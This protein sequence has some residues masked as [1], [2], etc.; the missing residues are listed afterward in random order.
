[1]IIRPSKIAWLYPSFEAMLWMHMSPPLSP[2]TYRPNIV[3]P[4]VADF[5]TIE[6]MNL[7]VPRLS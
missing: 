3:L 1:M 4:R 5:S 2:F 7:F 6:M